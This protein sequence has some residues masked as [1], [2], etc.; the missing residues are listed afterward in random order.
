V[1]RCYD[2]ATNTVPLAGYGVL[3]L[4]ATRALAPGWTL[5]A[6]VDNLFD[7]DYQLA[8]TYPTGGRIVQVGLRWQLL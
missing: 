7:R 2:N 3:H 1:G 8:A 5:E 6:R 4:R